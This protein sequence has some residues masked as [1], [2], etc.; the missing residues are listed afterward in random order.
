MTAKA[1][2]VAAILKWKLRGLAEIQKVFRN[3]PQVILFRLGFITRVRAEWRSGEST[4]VQSPNEWARL[5]LRHLWCVELLKA[6]GLRASAVDSEIQL[7]FQDRLLR[8]KVDP[9]LEAYS[10]LLE[11]FVYQDYKWLRVEGRQ[12]LDV[13]ASIGD[14]AIYFAARGAAQVYALEPYPYAYKF[15]ETNIRLN[16][17]ERKVT[18]LNLG[19]GKEGTTIVDPEF[20]NDPS[21]VLA[22]SE[23]GVKLSVFSLKQIVENFGLN[24]AVAK[25]DCEG[26]EYDLIL[27]AAD[28]ELRTFSQMIIEY[29]REFSSL[30]DRMERAG[31]RVVRTPHFSLKDSDAGERREVG[32]IKA[33]RLPK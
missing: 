9:A 5:K 24:D 23:T 21:S 4:V 2:N 33:E 29:H 17:L 15:A 30:M 26:C 14:S 18:L 1:D 6:Y 27:E 3:W 12:V 19:C 28:R 20:K 10:V 11:Q 31:F 8:F 13:G 32:L 7:L 22:A 16:A 25:V